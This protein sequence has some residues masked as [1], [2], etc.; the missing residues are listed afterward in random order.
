VGAGWGCAV[1]AATP[2]F[3]VGCLCI[4]PTWHV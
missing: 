2:S 3:L 1:F 4:V